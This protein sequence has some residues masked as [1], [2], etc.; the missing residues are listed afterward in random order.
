[1]LSPSS[2]ST[3]APRDVGQRRRLARQVLEERRPADV[4]GVGF[5]REAVAGRHRQRAPALVALEHAARTAARN[6][7]AVT[8]LSIACWISCSV[9]QMSFRYT[10]LP[11]VPVP[12]GSVVE[13]DVHRAGQRVGDDQRRRRQVVGAHVL[14]DAAFEVAVAAQHRRDDEPALAHLGGDLVGQRAAVA[15]ARRAAVADEVEAELIEIRL[16][17][18]LAQVLGDDLRARRQAGLDPRLAACRPCSTAF[19]ATRPAPIITLGFEVLVQLVMAAITT[20]PCSSCVSVAT[21]APPPAAATFFTPF[22]RSGSAAG[23][24]RLGA[25]SAATRSCG[26]RGPARL[27]TTVARSSSSVSV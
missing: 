24:R 2:A 9:G 4:G 15:D 25:A 8:A 23:K 10:G 5:P 16:Q 11:S 13:I 6:I 1:M 21:A 22:C 18:G 27:G 3:R 12:S 7:S 17:A 19:F 20:E 14:L 26:R